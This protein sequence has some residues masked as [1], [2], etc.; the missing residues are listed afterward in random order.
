MKASSNT[1]KNIAEISID[2]KRKAPKSERFKCFHKEFHTVKYA[3]KC[4][5][6]SQLDSRRNWSHN[7]PASLIPQSTGVGL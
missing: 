6:N 1:S 7:W 3:K 2:H 5:G 4:C